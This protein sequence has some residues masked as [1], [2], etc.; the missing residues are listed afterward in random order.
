MKKEII[1]LIGC[2]PVLCHVTA[3]PVNTVTLQGLPF[4]ALRAERIIKAQRL[5]NKTCPYNSHCR[6]VPSPLPQGF[7]FIT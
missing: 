6:T 1:D 3:A 7:V 4:P 2:L 5:N